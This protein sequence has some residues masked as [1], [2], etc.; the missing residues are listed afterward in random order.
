MS[1]VEDGTVVPEETAEAPAPEEVQTDE[2][3]ESSPSPEDTSAEPEEKPKA[4]GVQKRIDELTA[5]WRAEQR[6][7]EQLQEALLRQQPSQ[8]ETEAPPVTSEK[9]QAD[10]FNSYEEYIEALTDWKV[11]QKQS[12]LEEVSARR[13]EADAAAQREQTFQSRA[14]AFES[15]HD[16]FKAVAMNPLLPVSDAMAQAVQS[17]E[18]GPQLLYHLGQNPEEAARIH[19]LPPV[20]AAMEMGRLEAVL[21]ATQPNRQTSAPNPIEPLEG[22]Q[23]TVNKDPDKMT[24][25]EWQAWRKETMGKNS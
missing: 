7:A 13:R 17:S 24:M 19:Q 8:P 1:E 12:E 5:N 2:T 10:A 15:E 4:K 6:R 9:P 3:E 21:T 23:G 25:A 14:V 22:G 16:D 20:A 18:A 11:D